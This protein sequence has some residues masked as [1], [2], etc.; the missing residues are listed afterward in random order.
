MVIFKKPI[1]YFE[2]QLDLILL[3]KNCNL[4]ALFT[5][6]VFDLGGASFLF[7]RLVEK[8]EIKNII[9]LKSIYKVNN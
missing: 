8:E 6:M 2:T 4:L 5:R 9:F 7:M 1:T 3:G